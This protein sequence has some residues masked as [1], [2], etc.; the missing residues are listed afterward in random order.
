MDHYPN[1]EI[2]AH[3]SCVRCLNLQ[4][5]PGRIVG[6]VSLVYHSLDKRLAVE[7]AGVLK[8]SRSS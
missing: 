5:R 2:G 6:R 4:S 3:L 1:H 8:D 7:V